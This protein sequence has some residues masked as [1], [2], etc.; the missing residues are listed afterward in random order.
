MKKHK[1]GAFAEALKYEIAK[2]HMCLLVLENY[3]KNMLKESY[4][5]KQ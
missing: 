5:N 2:N 1:P 3:Y 4:D